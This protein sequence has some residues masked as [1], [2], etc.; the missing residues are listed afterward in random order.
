RQSHHQSRV[1]RIERV[2][3]LDGFDRLAAPIF[4]VEKLRVALVTE[5]IVGCETQAF[6][7]ELVCPGGIGAETRTLDVGL[8]K[9]RIQSERSIESDESIPPRSLLLGHG[10]DT[11]ARRQI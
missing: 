3:A 9:S 2:R 5:P 10:A 7:I 4:V 8:A 6:P 1:Q 11:E